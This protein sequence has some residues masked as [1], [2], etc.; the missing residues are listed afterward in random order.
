MSILVSL[1][2]VSQFLLKSV[3]SLDEKSSLYPLDQDLNAQ[4]WKRFPCIVGTRYRTRR[5]RRSQ[6]KRG[7][8]RTKNLRYSNVLKH[9]VT[10][11]MIKSFRKLSVIAPPIRWPC[12]KINQDYLGVS[13]LQYQKCFKPTMEVLENT[14]KWGKCR[15][16]GTNCHRFKPFCASVKASK[17][18][19]RKNWLLTRKLF[20]FKS[21]FLLYV[22]PRSRKR[23]SGIEN[24]WQEFFLLS[25]QRMCGTGD[26]R[27]TELINNSEDSN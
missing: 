8:G 7:L 18:Q 15:N 11:C 20:W 10:S 17:M 27:W 3:L 13:K 6:G 26:S 16:T 5:C 24:D 9:P 12:W 4:I 14:K 19:V 22:C 2:I 21:L 1:V 25:D 23:R